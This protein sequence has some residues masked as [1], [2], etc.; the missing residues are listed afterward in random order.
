MTSTAPV[1]DAWTSHLKPNVPAV[2]NVTVA[3]GPLVSA[4][5]IGFG[6]SPSSAR[7]GCVVKLPFH[8]TVWPALI[9]RQRGLTAKVQST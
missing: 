1:I 7:S 6:V 2:G 8:V 3:L 4:V 9:W 5:E